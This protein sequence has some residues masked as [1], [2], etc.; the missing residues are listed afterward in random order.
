MTPSAPISLNNGVEMPALGLGVFQSAP[1]ETVDAVE[2]GDNTATKQC[3]PAAGAAESL[4]PR[5]P[6]ARLRAAAA[7]V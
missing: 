1:A 5:F 3:R 2:G 4:L 7:V 6:S